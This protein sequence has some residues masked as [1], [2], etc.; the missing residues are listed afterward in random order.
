MINILTGLVHAD[1]GTVRFRGNDITGW[2][3]H[4]VCQAGI[5][6]TF[7]NLRLF[8]ELSVLEDVLLGQHTRL[9]GGFAE[10]L[11][12]L[13]RSHA[14]EAV[15]LTKARAILRFVGLEKEENLAA[16]SLPYGLQRRVELA[17]ALATEPSLL[18]LDE[19]AAG[20]NHGEAKELGQLL[21]KIRGVGISIL[22]IE[23]HMEVVM[24]ISDR[25]TVLDYGEVIAEGTPVEVR[26]DPRVVEAYFG[27]AQPHGARRAADARSPGVT[28]P[29][30]VAITGP[31][32]P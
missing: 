12:A 16:G 2:A 27:S 17:R 6:R 4:R 9:H 26:H 8:D 1:A 25:V 7:Q 22:L 30:G 19:P 13:P 18:L 24:E 3:P 32:V 21:L 23:H 20:L 14:D 5:A 29:L 31:A 15:A 28:M 10:N 11:L